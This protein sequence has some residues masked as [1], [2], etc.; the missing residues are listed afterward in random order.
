[1]PFC[2]ACGVPGLCESAWVLALSRSRRTGRGV[3]VHPAGVDRRPARVGHPDV[4]VQDRLAG[5][6][7]VHGAD[8]GVRG[9]SR[10]QLIRGSPRASVGVPSAVAVLLFLGVAMMAMS[11]CSTGS[12]SMRDAASATTTSTRE[13]AATSTSLAAI[14]R[15]LSCPGGQTPRRFERE[16]APG[17]RLPS[18]ASAD[19]AL[20]DYLGTDQGARTQLLGA[21]SDGAHYM[22]LDTDGTLTE[23]VVVHAAT[24]WV[25]QLTIAC[26]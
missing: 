3:R 15:A 18:F 24:G 25:A 21:R 13:A 22:V 11:G 14:P 9:M 20:A 8:L 5:R 1:M 10:V 17:G 7:M 19:A 23:V 16:P 12:L 6:R 4:P 26:G 2:V